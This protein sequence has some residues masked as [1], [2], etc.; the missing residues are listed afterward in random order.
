MHFTHKEEWIVGVNKEPPPQKLVMDKQK[1]PS[2]KRVV[3][4]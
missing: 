4:V 1:Q 3:Q 2:T